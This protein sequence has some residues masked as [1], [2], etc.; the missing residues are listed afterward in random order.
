MPSTR[1]VTF[2]LLGVLYVSQYLGVG[3]IYFG[4][5]PILRE[6]GVGLGSI[7]LIHAIGAIWAVK[8]LWAPLVD[9]FGGQRAGHYRAWV[10]YLQPFVALAIASLLL[11]TEPVEQIQHIVVVVALY[12]AASATQDLAVDA[13]A[14]R[15]VS[16]PDRG[17]ANGLATAG[18][19][20]GNILGGGLV[21]VVHGA[22]G[23]TAAVLVLTGLTLLPLL[24][25]VPFREPRW[26]TP[27]TPLR[28][29]YGAFL[30]VFRQPGCRSWAFVVVPLFFV[31]TSSVYGL[32]STALVDA[33][34]G[35][36][37]IG[38]T[39]GVVIG[40]P[41]VVAATLTGALVARVGHRAT[42]VGSGAGCVVATV[43]LMPLMHGTAPPVLTTVTI[44]A[45]VAAMSAATTVTFT[46]NMSY[47]RP[48]TAATDFTA[49]A[50]YA[51]ACTFAVG[52]L[53]MALAGRFGYPS[54]VWVSV[55]LTTLG[56]AAA[57]W[58]LARHDLD[59]RDD[60]PPATSPGEASSEPP[61]LAT[62]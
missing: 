26:A 50:S 6:Q 13:L 39:M 43:A 38:V 59:R 60:A 7:G 54:V 55:V 35:L 42:V 33:G 16:P 21:V 49:L 56:T 24:V 30:T 8:L 53:L 57:A 4:L 62:S 17:Q 5:T 61:A 37:R 41:A 15:L 34:W 31:G 29:G 22:Y 3:F 32:I 11:V 46:V 58:H 52:G 45:Y 14:V 9:R 27:P 40:V 18:A 10:L 1:H 28:Q 19:W 51:T 25:V 36:T 2:R 23:W 47:S 44:S 48:E 20:G 12:V